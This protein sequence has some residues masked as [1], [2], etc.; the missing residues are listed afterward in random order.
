MKKLI[1]NCLSALLC[2]GCLSAPL[3][4]ADESIDKYA[5]EIPGIGLISDCIEFDGIKISNFY[6]END[7]KFIFTTPGKKIMARL[8]CDIDADALKTL[9]RHHLIIGLYDDGPQDCIL[10]VYGVKNKHEDLCVTIKAPDKPGVYQI[11]FCH[12]IGLTDEQAHKAWWRGDGPSAKTIAGI[13][14]VK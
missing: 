3:L 13:V 9:Q 1:R 6:F 5:K 2:I 4:A 12:A 10:H 14:V 11:R 8:H 7:K